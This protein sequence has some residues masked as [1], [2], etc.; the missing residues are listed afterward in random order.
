MNNKIKDLKKFS[1]IGS[2]K[3]FSSI[4][5]LLRNIVIA[6]LVGVEDYAVIAIFSAIIATVEIA[7]DLGLNHFIIRN[8]ETVEIES[9]HWLAFLKGI[10]QAFVT[11]GLIFFFVDYNFKHIEQEPTE[12]VYMLAFYPI[13]RGMLN[14]GIYIKQGD[15]NLLPLIN[16]ELIGNAGAFLVVIIASYWID[17]YRIGVIGLLSFSLFSLSASHFF[18]NERYSV[19][20]SFRD[21]KNIK[22]FGAP[23]LVNGLVLALSSHGERLISSK[24][25]PLADFGLL[26]IALTLTTLVYSQS[27]SLILAFFVPRLTKIQPTSFSK[28]QGELFF[29]A[30]ICIFV[31]ICMVLGYTFIGPWI[32]EFVYGEKYVNATAVLIILGVAQAIRLLK[33]FCISIFFATDNT[34]E[35]LILGLLRALCTP[36]ILYCSISYNDVII[37]AQAMVVA[38]IFSL[39]GGLWLTN[40]AFP[41]AIRVFLRSLIPQVSSTSIILATFWYFF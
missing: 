2:A 1:F 12:F 18:S 31:S 14:H 10:L 40:R 19:H 35:L 9:I 21:F 27:Y 37:F 25:F 7:F 22:R 32:L 33:V 6:R 39:C 26:A 16:T 15:G 24:S 4:V 38:E 17:D 20:A 11:V 30:R 5:G 8:K 36:L 29:F 13:L 41:G 23:I 28:S 3:V 34:S